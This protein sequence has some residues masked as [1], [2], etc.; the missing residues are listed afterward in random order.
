MGSGNSVRSGLKCSEEQSCAAKRAQ[1]PPAAYRNTASSSATTEQHQT[2]QVQNG[3]FCSD[4]IRVSPFSCWGPFNL[5]F[6]YE[7]LTGQKK[8]IAK[9]L[10]GSC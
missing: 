6:W 2:T 5:D 4:L 10:T 7:A 3:A 1:Y 8:K 9:P